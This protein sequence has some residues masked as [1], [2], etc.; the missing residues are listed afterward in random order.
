ME[1]LSTLKEFKPIEKEFNGRGQQKC[2][3]FKCLKRVGDIALYEKSS[4]DGVGKWWEVVVIRKQEASDN[5]IGG[6]V[7]HFEAKER[8]PSDEQFGV[9]GWCYSTLSAAEKKFSDMIPN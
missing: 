6:V 7:V 4:T 5:L 2:F 9:D 1:N 3:Y 8:Y